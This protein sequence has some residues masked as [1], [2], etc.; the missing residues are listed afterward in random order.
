MT[1]QTITA[2]GGVFDQGT[3]DIVNQNFTDLY[4]S[5]IKVG[6][7]FYL[8]PANGNDSNAGDSISAAKATL[9]GA[10]NLTTAGKN[11]VVVLV[12]NGQASGSARLSAN[13]DWSKDA[14][15][16]VGIAA[17]TRVGGR[18]RIAP[19]SGATAF[20]NFFTVSGDGCLFQN[21]HWF[22]GF[23]TGTT[24]QICIT[25]TGERNA[26]KNCHIGGMGDQESADNAGS[27]SLKI[28]SGG[29]GENTFID[30]TI[31]LDTVTRGAANASIEFAGATPRNSFIN[32][33]LPFHADAATPLAIIGSGSGN[34][35]RWQYFMGCSFIN[36]AGSGSTTLTAMITLAASSGGLVL[37]K[38]CT[39]VGATDW[40]SDTTTEAQV[41]LDGAA[42]TATTSGIA[43]QSDIS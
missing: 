2:E 10:Y 36:N 23:S 12:G 40:A 38:D 39:S 28:G 11:D 31:G 16:L 7:V 42:P 18:A 6:D 15:H 14:T 17:P 41:W 4:G 22:H 21:I 26:F 1:Q 24:S 37:L 25:I 30:C 5:L 35:D 19:T 43:V 34:M 20:A 32:C 8:D 33:I 29:T 3:R 27:R 9:S 13:F